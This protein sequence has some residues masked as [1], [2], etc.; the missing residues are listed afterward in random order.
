VTAA[1]GRLLCV[2]PGPAIAVPE[3]RVLDPTFRE[4]FV[5]LIS[6]LDSQVLEEAC[7]TTKKA[8]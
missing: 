6:R 1:K 2:F 5:E 8:K 4:A 3:D 7:P